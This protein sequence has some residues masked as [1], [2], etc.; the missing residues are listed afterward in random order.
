MTRLNKER[1][2]R[3]TPRSTTF[4]VPSH[5]VKICS[6]VGKGG[7]RIGD[8]RPTTAS[9]TWSPLTGSISTIFSRGTLKSASFY[10]ILSSIRR[11][12]LRLP[13]S[14]RLSRR[15]G[16]SSIQATVLRF[17]FGFVWVFV[18]P[19]EWYS[20]PQE[21]FALGRFVYRWMIHCCCCWSF[22]VSVATIRLR[23]WPA[24]LNFVR[25]L[26]SPRG[27]VSLCPP[28]PIRRLGYQSS[29][30]LMMSANP[31]WFSYYRTKGRV[32][33]ELSPCPIGAVPGLNLEQVPSRL[34]ALRPDFPKRIPDNN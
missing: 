24:F 7:C 30:R 16:M 28:P 29:F 3:F 25:T 21:A 17:P 8:D 4:W 14:R 2:S 33:W 12:R 13:P 19:G 15:Q 11:I 23:T 22:C 34:Q 20:S 6:V 10:R 26:I 32:T 5:R 27:G 1:L 31:L 9:W 18:S